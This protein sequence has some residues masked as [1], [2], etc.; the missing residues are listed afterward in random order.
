MYKKSVYSLVF[1]F[2]LYSFFGC[3]Y[4][5][6][7]TNELNLSLNT[8]SGSD[9]LFRFVFTGDSRGNY[10]ANPPDHIAEE[11]LELYAQRILSLSPKPAFVIFNG[12]MVAKT[13]YRN[14]GDAIKIWKTVFEMPI[15]D[16]GIKMFITPGNH[17]FY[18]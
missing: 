18:L 6:K 15:R 12:D 14:D 2:A 17:I 5:N 8:E 7:K 16:A 9:I 3:S 13:A 10:K 4:F 1:L 11:I